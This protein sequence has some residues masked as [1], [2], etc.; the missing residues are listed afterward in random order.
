M[1]MGDRKVLFANAFDFIRG[2][3][4]VLLKWPKW[5]MVDIHDFWEDRWEGEIERDPGPTASLDRTS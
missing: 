3:S 5:S 4:N 2:K 1:N